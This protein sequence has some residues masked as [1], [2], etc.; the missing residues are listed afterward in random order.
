MFDSFIINVLTPFFF[1]FSILI[2]SPFDILTRLLILHYSLTLASLF[3][4]LKTHLPITASI[5]TSTLILELLHTHY[6]NHILFSQYYHLHF[7]L[8]YSHFPIFATIIK[9]NDL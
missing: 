4:I 2:Q 3:A 6:L 5:I 7:I 9:L 1:T 8:N